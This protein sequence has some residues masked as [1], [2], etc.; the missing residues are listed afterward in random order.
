MRKSMITM[1]I[2][3]L[4][5]TFTC[6]LYASDSTTI[7]TR[8]DAVSKVIQALYNNTYSNEEKFDIDSYYCLHASGGTHFTPDDNLRK[9]GYPVLCEIY[10]NVEGPN[11]SDMNSPENSIS[12]AKAMGII[13]GLPDGT[14]HP[15]EGLT[16][17]QAYA[18]LTSA[19]YSSKINGTELVLK[20]SITVAKNIGFFNELV[21]EDEKVTIIDF[22]RML[23]Y[24]IQ[25]TKDDIRN[26]LFMPAFTADE[27]I[28]YYA[29]AIKT[30]NGMLQYALFDKNLQQL[31][32]ADFESRGWL[33]DIPGIWVESFSI[34]KINNLKYEI[35]FNWVTS[36]K[37]ILT[38]T[39]GVSTVAVNLG[40][41]TIYL[42]TELENIEEMNTLYNTTIEKRIKELR[43]LDYSVVGNWIY[44]VVMGEEEGFH[45]MLL[46][47]TQDS[48]ICDFSNITHGIN[49]STS[50]TSE[51]KE[52][53]ILYK[54]QAL[55]EYDENGQL[56]ED[57]HPIA[58]YR[59]NLYDNL[60][61]PIDI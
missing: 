34:E 18:I 59:L 10:N 22:E 11:F 33:T 61:E 47:G 8:S 36:T 51:V 12:L 15:D 38:T 17:N 43:P 14:F 32:K 55:R 4:F 49:G 35:T 39:I 20:D 58:Y 25:N 53:Y 48:L 23:N 6:T 50:I 26:V 37:T 13:N 31:Y 57:S 52:G 46:D 45:K 27:C 54:F 29:N 24:C 21:K 7:I 60:L 30:H 19:F 3:I 41:S 40:E 2:A 56:C 44:Y 9:A 5:I 42:I 1:C 28:S 16:Y